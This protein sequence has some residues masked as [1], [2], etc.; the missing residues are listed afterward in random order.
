MGSEALPRDTPPGPQL[1]ARLEPIAPRTRRRRR[2]AAQRDRTRLRRLPDTRW[3]PVSVAA[4]E[5][6]LRHWRANYVRRCSLSDATPH[7][8]SRTPHRCLG[9]QYRSPQPASISA[10]PTPGY[11]RQG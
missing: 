2:I 9:I 3:D 10:N 1:R 4:R 8:P 7:S 6:I 11:K 5:K